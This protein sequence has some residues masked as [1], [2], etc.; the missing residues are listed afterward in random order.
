MKAYYVGW[1]TFSGKFI[2][3]PSF[4]EEYWAYRQTYHMMAEKNL[5]AKTLRERCVNDKV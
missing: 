1:P 4:K 2:I 3:Y 5:V